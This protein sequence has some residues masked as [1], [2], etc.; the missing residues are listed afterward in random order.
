MH[1]LFFLWTRVRL[2][3]SGLRGKEKLCE[4]RSIRVRWARRKTLRTL[5]LQHL[6][7]SL[8]TNVLHCPVVLGPQT[9][10]LSSKG[11]L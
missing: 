4:N 7:R 8:Y 9:H 5:H 2:G 3:G 11:A 1:L 6:Y 10:D